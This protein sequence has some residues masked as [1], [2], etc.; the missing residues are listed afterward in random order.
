MKKNFLKSTTVLTQ[1]KGASMVEYGLILAAVAFVSVT[2]VVVFGQNVSTYFS[3]S[4]E[5]LED[6]EGFSSG[7]ITFVYAD[8]V[9]LVIPEDIFGHGPGNYLYG[10]PYSDFLENDGSYDGIYGLATSDIMRG[11]SNS[12]IFVGGLGD[13]RISG[14]KGADT[15]SYARGDGI[16]I[17]DERGGDSSTDTLQ[18]LD[19]NSTD[20]TGTR[21]EQNLIMDFGQGDGMV[22]QGYFENF[23]YDAH[24]E[25]VEF[26][27]K[28]L[29]SVQEFRDFVADIQ[30]SSGIVK[31]TKQNENYTHTVATDGSYSLDDDHYLAPVGLGTFTFTDANVDDV[32]IRRVP[33][34]SD[35]EMTTSD[36]DIIRVIQF[37]Y[38]NANRKGFSS[39]VFQ[40][41]TLDQYDIRSKA[42]QDQQAAG[43]S[44]FVASSFEE[45]LV[46]DMLEDGSYTF[47]NDNYSGVTLERFE[48]EN[49]NVS[50]LTLEFMGGLSS[51]TDFKITFS[52]GDEVIIDGAFYISY[53]TWQR[54]GISAIDV[55]GDPSTSADDVALE[56]EDIVAKVHADQKP[57]GFV[58]GLNGPETFV[59]NLGDPNVSY[60]A[61]YGNHTD[62]VDL[63]DFAQSDVSS[64]SRE[65]YS[66]DLRIEFTN[67]QVLVI[68]NQTFSTG[69]VEELHF[70]DG[71]VDAVSL[72]SS[73][74]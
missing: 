72:F 45:R 6:P 27:D 65:R 46:H 2:S 3:K 70:S 73:T 59:Y 29:T 42:F 51:V 5:Y 48:I 64:Y 10:T 69:R 12:E 50:D 32:I 67:G 14:Y 68:Q 16:D 53:P 44:S 24:F 23:E 26:A 52:D 66:R 55:L 28:T 34:G 22:I 49:A 1:N 39:L 19:V 71:V 33:G 20:V 47:K 31:G 37:D 60:Y 62:I 63:T 36:G 11:N 57:T 21:Q 43:T 61:G 9:P 13:D 17:I 30:K 40:D 8:P 35:Y 58:R 7:E 15:Y 74:S 18:F 4:A 38:V 41:A 56:L 25:R 54:R